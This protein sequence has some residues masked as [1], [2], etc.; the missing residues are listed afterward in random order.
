MDNVK[1]TKSTNN[2]LTLSHSAASLKWHT[3]QN[4]TNTVDTVN[5]HT[6]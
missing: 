4:P 1:M 6:D 5:N 2:P 3:Y